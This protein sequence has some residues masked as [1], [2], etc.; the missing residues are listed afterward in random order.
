MCVPEHLPLS[1]ASKLTTIIQNRYAG[2]FYGDSLDNLTFA[3][4]TV[5]N[6][7]LIWRI[8]KSGSKPVE[9]RLRGHEVLSLR[10]RYSQNR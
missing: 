7:V 1:Q 5:W 10:N 4:G 6:E 2:R 9:R 3:A 8:P